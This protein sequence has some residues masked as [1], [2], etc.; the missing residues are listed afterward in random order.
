M[1]WLPQELILLDELQ[2]TIV[3]DVLPLDS[4]VLGAKTIHHIPM[5]VADNIEFAMQSI[6]KKWITE[7]TTIAFFL[8][9]PWLSAILLIIVVLTIWGII[10]KLPSLFVQFWVSIF[11]SPFILGRSLLTNKEETGEELVAT[12]STTDLA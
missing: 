2:R 5:H 6:W 4:N 8:S 10:Q 3:D 1:V 11:K 9:H 7:H 12:D